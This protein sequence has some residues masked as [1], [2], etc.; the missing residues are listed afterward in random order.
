MLKRMQIFYVTIYLILLFATFIFAQKK[1]ADPDPLRFKK[2]I[3]TFKKWDAK[4]SFP[5]NAILF[6]GSSSIR[7]WKTHKGF[8]EFPVINRGFGGAH[9]SDVLYFY[10]DVIKKYKSPIIVFYAGDND[11]AADKT[12]EQVKND[13]IKL[14]DKIKAD[15]PEVKLIYIPIKPSIS[16]WQ[17]WDKMNRVN[18]QI[19]K[20]NEND[21]NLY[22]IDLAAPLLDKSG[23]PKK[24]VFISDGLH[25]NKKGY[26][27]W[28]KLLLPMLDDLYKK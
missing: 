15:N 19:K 13:Y 17:Y 4:N 5:E 7:K 14:V 18:M 3:E 10:N 28:E 6:V 11:I 9:I 22:Y 23:N 2:E 16:R 24:D 20:Y 1:I 12:I 26:A 8:P 27:L 21:K 25:L